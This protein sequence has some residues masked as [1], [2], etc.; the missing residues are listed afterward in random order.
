[1]SF[2][3][4]YFMAAVAK[5]K[6][7]KPF[8]ERLREMR[9]AAGISQVEMAKRLGIVRQTYIRWEDGTTEPTFSA[10]CQLARV[11]GVELSDFT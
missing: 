10:L 8:A 4:N 7:S 5:K 1:M 2:V 6:R 9:E 11:L 3:R